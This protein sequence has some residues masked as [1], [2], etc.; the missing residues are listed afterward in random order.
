[1]D[2]KEEFGADLGITQEG[3]TYEKNS[4]GANFKVRTSNL[5]VMALEKKIIEMEE[6]VGRRGFAGS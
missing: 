6:M 1:M 5:D 4:R 3:L 2:T